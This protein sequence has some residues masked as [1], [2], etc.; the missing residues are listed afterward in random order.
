MEP[1]IPR[2]PRSPPASLP[3]NPSASFPSPT[4][5]KSSF[6][7]RRL[8]E[9]YLLRF[10]GT[11]KFVPTEVE[12]MPLIITFLDVFGTYVGP[13]SQ[14]GIHLSPTERAETAGA[15]ASFTH[16]CLEWQALIDH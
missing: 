6:T 2:R 11:P 9:E 13:A 7:S 12:E 8:E 10:T 5:S 4:V 1:A 16:L 15:A 14:A 3:L